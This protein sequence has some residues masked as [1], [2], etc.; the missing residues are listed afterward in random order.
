MARSQLGFF[1]EYIFLSNKF[2]KAIKLT[3]KFVKVYSNLEL[4]LIRFKLL[5]LSFLVDSRLS[6]FVDLANSREFEVIFLK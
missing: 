2:S 1:F 3:S 6:L 4:N 5:S